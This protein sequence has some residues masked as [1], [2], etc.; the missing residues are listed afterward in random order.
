MANRFPLIFNSGAGQIQELAASDNLDLTSSNLVN[1]GILFTSSGSATAPSLQ[2]GSGTTYNPGLYS[3]GTDQLAVATNGTGRLFV[4][5]SGN[6]GV[7]TASPSTYGKFAVVDTQDGFLSSTFVNTSNGVS[8]VNRIQIG[9]DGSNGAG[10]LVVYGSQH[11]T[12]ANIFDVNNANPA[13]LRLLTNNTERARIRSDGTFEIKGAG[14]AGSSPG[15][16][17]NPSTPANSFV[18]DSSGRLGIGDSAPESLLHLKGSNATLKIESS[19][20]TGYSGVEFDRAADDTLF[21]IYAYDSSHASQANN[22]QF[23]GYQNG[24]IQFITNSNATP[25][26]TI[27][28]A[29]LVG[30]GSNSPGSELHVAASSGYAE[31][32]LAGA[33]GSG[34]SVEFYNS[35]TNLGDIFIDASNNMIFR[36]AS[37][38]FRV[39]SS[40]RLLVGTSTSFA[41]L[42][43]NI[44]GNSNNGQIGLRNTD[45]TSGRYWTIGPN[46]NNH[47][48]VYNQNANGVYMI[49]DGSSWTGVSDERF[50]TD[51]K[52]IE[53]ALNKVSTLR[54]V[55]GRFINDDK[56]ISRSFLIAQDVFAVLPEAVDKT[57][58]EK[59]GLS[60]TD[61]I[62]LLVAA[63]KESKVC[64][65]NLEA[66]LSALESA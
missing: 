37:E 38:A 18:I 20:N 27:T 24:N 9:N 19:V 23:Y 5:A 26:L 29:G 33:S 4:D 50:K 7:N 45:A 1:A 22:V 48:V 65:E 46:P 10:Q 49:N 64:I 44:Q 3:P 54:A 12:L 2:I 61:V 16:S 31:L 41:S 6:V 36:N 51:L 8:A 35:T 63:L 53:N 47:I 66:R 17:V 57:N 34:G 32:R 11:S 15:F 62:P 59:L 60:Y 55:T 52:P 43:T 13:A 42:P 25:R 39:D 28:S 58:P 30:I 56:N 14:T 40:R 21:A